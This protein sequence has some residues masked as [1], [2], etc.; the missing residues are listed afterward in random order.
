MIALLQ[1]LGMLSKPLG[2]EEAG[3]VKKEVL[4]DLIVEYRFAVSQIE[5][6]K[7][8]GTAH[9]SLNKIMRE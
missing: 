8:I 3:S 2:K 6:D 1:W 7:C 5:E 4:L 9:N